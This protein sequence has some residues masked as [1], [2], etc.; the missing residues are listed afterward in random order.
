LLEACVRFLET[1]A[2]AHAVFLSWEVPLADVVLR[3]ILRADAHRTLVNGDRPD[4]LPLEAVRAY[5][6]GEPVAPKYERRLAEALED[7]GPLLT[8]LRLVDGDAV[9]RNVLSMLRE[10]ATWMRE[11]D[12]PTVGLVAVDYFQK[13]SGPPGGN[14]FSRQ[15]ELRAVSDLLRRFAKGARLTTDSEHGDVLEKAYEVP[16]LV[17]A[18]VNRNDAGANSSTGHPTGDNIRESDDLLQDASTVLSLS[19]ED[20][21]NPDNT[22]EQVR[23]LRVSVPKH[24]GGASAA[25][26]ARVEWRPARMWISARCKRDAGGRVTWEEPKNDTGAGNGGG[27]IA[28]TGRA[29]SGDTVPDRKRRG[30]RGKDA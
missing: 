13:L 12:A 9:G 17:G 25:D 20:L 15:N 24:R 7:V 28:N 1:N 8:R 14:V 16:V 3:L 5:G 11:A 26:V 18:Q 23:Y 10:V 21:A 4:P 6:R 2:D 22:R 30:T 29:F 19:W 27:N